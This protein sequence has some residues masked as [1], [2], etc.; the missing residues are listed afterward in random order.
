MSDEQLGGDVEQMATLE[1]EMKKQS[2]ALDAIITGLEGSIRAFDWTGNDADTFK[3]SSWPQAIKGQLGSVRDLL[4]SAAT[5]LR[6]NIDAQT[7][8]SQGG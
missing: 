3:N 8:A 7:E 4:G 5:S 6:A 1:V 2:G